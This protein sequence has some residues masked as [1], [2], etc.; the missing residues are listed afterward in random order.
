MLP[1]LCTATGFSLTRHEIRPFDPTYTTELFHLRHTDN[2]TA[3]T[4]RQRTH[5]VSETAHMQASKIK[6]CRQ[7][8]NKIREVVLL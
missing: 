4:T 7:D 2:Q 3:R 1:N 6:L 5:T 8:D